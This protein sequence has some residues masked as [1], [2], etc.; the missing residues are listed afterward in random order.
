M[1][2]KLQQLLS[3][4]ATIEQPG[5]P[6]TPAAPGSVSVYEKVVYLSACDMVR[7]HGRDFGFFAVPGLS[8]IKDIEYAMP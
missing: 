5:G 2:I 7:A 1:A 3:D 4:H 8:G 6:A